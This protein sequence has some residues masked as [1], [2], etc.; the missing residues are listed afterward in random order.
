MFW[1]PGQFIKTRTAVN[2][3]RFQRHFVYC[4]VVHVICLFFCP[5]YVSPVSLLNTMSMN[6]SMWYVNSVFI[7]IIICGQCV[8]LSSLSVCPSVLVRVLKGSKWR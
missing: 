7:I 1:R 6:L 2:I 4:F 8:M 3:P 5:S